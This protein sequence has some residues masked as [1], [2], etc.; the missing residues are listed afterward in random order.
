MSISIAIILL[1]HLNTLLNSVAVLRVGQPGTGPPNFVFSPPT[2]LCLVHQILS[3]HRFYY[4]R[5][6][7]V[8]Y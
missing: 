7:I 2:F 3:G 4:N 5:L 8:G 6:I 1:V